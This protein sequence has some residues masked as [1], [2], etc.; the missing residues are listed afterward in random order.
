MHEQ[1]EPRTEST[2]SRQPWE[3]PALQT[4]RFDETA[5]GRFDSSSESDFL[6]AES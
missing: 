2:T 3:T 1:Q 5:S 6:N 4:L